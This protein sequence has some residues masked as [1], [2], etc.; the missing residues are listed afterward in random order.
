MGLDPRIW[1]PK[2]WF[3]LHSVALNYPKNPTDQDKQ[4]YKQFFE[5]I[6]YILPCPQCAKH[7]GENLQTN[8]IQLQSNID[9]NKW[10]V[11]M[12]NIV[13]RH[14]YKP[15]ITYEQFL[16]NYKSIYNGGFQSDTFNWNH[17]LIIAVILCLFVG[18]FMYRQYKKCN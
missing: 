11:E 12:H 1:G 8:P 9:L 4:N 5:S 15:T 6:Q 3:F 16:D 17:I 18:V 13:N 14:Y 7:Y 10:L 2:A